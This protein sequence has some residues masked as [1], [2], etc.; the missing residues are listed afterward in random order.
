MLNALHRLSDLMLI[1][2]QFSLLV[3]T[4]AFFF[5]FFGLPL[6][7][8]FF[9]FYFFFEEPF[10]ILLFK[11][12]SLHYLPTILR[13]PPLI[14][15]P[16][17]FV[18]VSFMHVPWWTLPFFPTLLPATL[19]S[20]YCQF[21]LYLTVSGYILLACLLRV[22]SCEF[23]LYFGDQTLVWGTIVKYVFPYG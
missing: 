1:T 5:F 12:S 21:V 17:G 6:F 22:D 15:H 9:L 16:F 7:L 20:G 2:I 11:Y 19:P 10:F 18:R 13:L 4:K 3:K 23:F 14:L 8:S